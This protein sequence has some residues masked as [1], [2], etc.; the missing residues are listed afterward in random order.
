MISCAKTHSH[1]NSD[2]SDYPGSSHHFR[3]FLW[4]F[5]A[6]NTNS[7]KDPSWIYEDACNCERKIMDGQTAKPNGINENETH[8]SES[9]K[10]RFFQR[11]RR[12]PK[13]GMVFFRAGV[14][15]TPASIAE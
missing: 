8:I 3:P 12:S 2:D 14:Y 1:S 13:H 10:Q 5:L 7:Q 9:P 6:G 11:L 4:I 15:K